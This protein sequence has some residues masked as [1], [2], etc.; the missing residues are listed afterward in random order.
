MGNFTTEA[1]KSSFT[2]QGTINNYKSVR[3]SSRSA[4]AAVG[5]K[6]GYDV[7]GIDV[8][9]VPATRTAIDNY[10]KGIKDYLNDFEAK[11]ETSGAF[12]GEAITQ[13]VKDYLVAVKEYVQNLVTYLNVF[14][15]KLKDVEEAWTSYQTS[16]GQ[17]I[18]STKSSMGTYSAYTT[19]K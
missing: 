11:A 15:D 14:S 3:E 19:Q 7:V 9:K 8:N 4:S 17:T 5:K 1:Q 2:T 12:K 10:V 6:A 18:S 16:M 13:G